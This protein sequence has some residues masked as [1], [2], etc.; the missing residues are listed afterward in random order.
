M[1]IVLAPRSNG[2][3]LFAGAPWIDYET[4][5]VDPEVSQ[6]IVSPCII[7]RFEETDIDAICSACFLVCDR[8]RSLNRLVTEVPSYPFSMTR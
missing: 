4:I 8:G 5:H 1:D 7:A 6:C 2:Q 3:D